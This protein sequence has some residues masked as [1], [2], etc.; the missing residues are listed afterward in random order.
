MELGEGANVAGTGGNG[1]NGDSF[2]SLF[3]LFPPVQ[4][5]WMGGAVDCRP[6]AC[7]FVAR[8]VW[9]GYA[10]WVGEEK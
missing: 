2:C 7:I 10:E 6:T 8:D 4:N 5:R 1:E 3:P 9:I